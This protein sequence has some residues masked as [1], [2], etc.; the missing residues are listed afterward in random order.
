LASHVS[1]VYC[2]QERGGLTPF[3]TALLDTDACFI[4]RIVAGNA[5]ADTRDVQ[6]HLLPELARPGQLAGAVAVVIDVLRATTTIIHALAAGC[7][8]VRPCAEIEEARELA[9]S[10]R[11]GR[12]LLGGERHG[13]P[14]PGFDLGN[15]PGDY[16]P[17][18]CRGSTLV[19]TTTNGTR[20]LL[21]AAEAERVLVAGFINFS[22][23][24]EQLY[25]DVRP[26]HILCAGTEG[27]ITL[28][29]VVLAGALVD[30][31]CEELDVSLNDSARVAWDCFDNHGKVLTGALEL[32][33]G[34]AN[35][36]RLGYD[37]DI[38]TAAEIDRFALVP[39]LRRDP[40]RVEIGSVGYVRK[41]WP[42]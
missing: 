5:M 16:K 31:L 27:E 39:E 7:A 21:R 3:R 33:H 17:R 36:R 2:Q 1:F 15:S 10:M 14:I 18:V 40:L 26:V 42:R 37:E 34:G 6:V 11:A 30:Y 41:H 13:K 28:E 32:S 24:C 4:M 35:L 23:V 9:G 22:A 25:K 8:C 19:M 20:A 12:L 38:K 29:D